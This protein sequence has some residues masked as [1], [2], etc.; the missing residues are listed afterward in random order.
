MTR[1]TL[2]ARCPHTALG[3]PCCQHVPRE[4]FALVGC[5]DLAVRETKRPTVASLQACLGAWLHGGFLN[6]VSKSVCI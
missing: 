6:S 4:R 1:Q 2:G 3:R 5:S